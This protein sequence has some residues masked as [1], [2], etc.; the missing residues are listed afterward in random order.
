[1]EERVSVIDVSNPG[2]V[3]LTVDAGARSVVL[4]LG[5]ERYRDKMMSFFEHWPEIHRRLPD[6]TEFDL[7]LDDRIT[8]LNGVTE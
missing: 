1:M 5:R 2:N 3:Q 6:A 8:A 7:R 4:G